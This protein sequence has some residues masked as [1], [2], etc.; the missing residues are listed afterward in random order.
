MPAP[1]SHPAPSHATRARPIRG[2]RPS[3]GVLAAGAALALALWTSATPAAGEV[4]ALPLEVPLDEAVGLKLELGNAVVSTVVTAASAPRLRVEAVSEDGPGEVDLALGSEAGEVT[5]SRSPEAPNAAVALRLE[6]VLPAG[7]P[8]RLT[9]SG[10]TVR[11][12]EPER[13]R[14]SDALPPTR[15]GAEGEEEPHAWTIEI[16]VTGSRVDLQGVGD[17]SVAAADS[18]VDADGTSG[19]LGLALEGG[20]A[21]VRDHLGALELLGAGAELVVLGLEGP[22]TSDLTGGSLILR[23]AEGGL[24]LFAEDAFVLLE[25]F[26]GPGRLEGTG[27]T[28]EVRDSGA[29]GTALELRGQALQVLVEELAADLAVDLTDGTLQGRAL[30]GRSVKVQARG[31]ATADLAGVAG[32]LDLK[33]PS[34]TSARVAD[35]GTKVGAEVVGGRLTVEGARLLDLLATEGAEV[36]ATGIERLQTRRLADAE[37]DLDLSAIAHDPALRLEGATRARVTLPTPCAVKVVGGDLLEGDRVRAS[38][39]ELFP[40]EQAPRRTTLR[41]RYGGREVTLTAQV[42]EGSELVVDGSS[43]P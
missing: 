25:R 40:A 28:L 12:T 21:T 27:G 37:L 14:R 11:V 41:H 2:R 42:A 5:L 9:G 8:L 17:A 23:D 19:A 39:C 20:S 1:R 6:V 18:R 31:I 24:T 35:A 30:T 34:G 38:G 43:A 13:P 32:A 7:L 16:G 29:P 10:L 33:L 36:T 26:R 15:S 3:A 4:V 22:L